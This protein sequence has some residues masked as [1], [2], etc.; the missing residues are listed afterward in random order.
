M[1]ASNNLILVGREGGP[2]PHEDG[3]H[4]GGGNTFA[5]RL[6]ER[7]RT[8]EERET[9]GFGGISLNPN[10]LSE[11]L[12]EP[13]GI[14]YPPEFSVPAGGTAEQSWVDMHFQLPAQVSEES[15]DAHTLS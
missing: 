2:R 3:P 4:G 11:E 9:G 15:S 1:K 10:D 6:Q 5:L 12:L 14:V 7:K 13:V 8:G